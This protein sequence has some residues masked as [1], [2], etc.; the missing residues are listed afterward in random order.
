MKLLLILL[1]SFLLSCSSTVV[2]KDEM[3]PAVKIQP[4][5]VAKLISKNNQISK[6][7]IVSLLDKSSIIRRDSGEQ[8]DEKFVRSCLKKSLNRYILF[9]CKD[10]LF[11]LEIKILGDK[12]NY[13]LI[14]QNGASVENRYLFKKELSGDFSAPDNNLESIVSY[15]L[16]SKLIKDKLKL[17][18]S[19]K[20][21]KMSAQSYFRLEL[22]PDS[23]EIYLLSGDLYPEDSHQRLTQI[24]FI[25]GKFVLDNK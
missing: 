24:K 21:L 5:E 9:Q 25:N 12:R 22:V 13:I 23:E 14:V 1:C 7:D 20:A 6:K 19:V 4:T 17:D 8:V 18:F 2:T 15:E 11:D 10:L 3:L 16:I